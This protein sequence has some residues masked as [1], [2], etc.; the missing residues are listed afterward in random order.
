MLPACVKVNRF[1]V[2]SIDASLFAG[3]IGDLRASGMSALSWLPPNGAV[4][5]SSRTDCAGC[6]PRRVELVEP[7]VEELHVVPF[8][9]IR[10]FEAELRGHRRGF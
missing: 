3:S 5:G 10:S 2:F 8:G 1:D 4:V 9:A 7:I 6:A